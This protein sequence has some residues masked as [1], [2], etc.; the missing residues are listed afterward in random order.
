MSSPQSPP[1]TNTAPQANEQI[2][3][4]A[5]DTYSAYAESAVTDTTSLRSSILKYKY[6][7]GRRYHSDAVKDGIYWGPN[8]EK[9][10][11]AEDLAHQMYTVILGGLSEAPISEPERV[12]DVGCGTG[13]WA[14]DFADEHP[15]SEVTG[16]DISPIQPGFI[17]PNVRFEVDD[18][19]KSWTYPDD[20]FDYVH[21]RSM[22]G[23]V[24]DWDKFFKTVINHVKPGGWVE[25]VEQSSIT[26]SDDDTIPPGGAV[27]KWT[28][29][30]DEIGEKLG[31][32]FRAAEAS[33]Q[34]MKDAGFTNVTERII[35]VPQG[36]W[37]KDKRLK[38]WG[39]WFQ[40]FV[41]EGL[42]GFV[43]RSFTDVLGW[44]YAEAQV[45]LAQ[46]RKEL[47]DPSIHLYS[48]CRIVCGQKP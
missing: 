28:A 30:Y 42:E 47:K 43:I 5:S 33:C 48:E 25:H 16:V 24:P 45:Y 36:T 7:N 8:D 35:K 22:L 41:L 26:R 19:N 17:P 12:L 40:Y 27:S 18:V 13:A 9:Q 15:T 29:Y 14:I 44:S 34:A 6:E 3:V 37:P 31:I 10:Q 39:Q 2:E 46:V 11:E 38:I 20:H 4:D 23:S 32:N 21:I 1:A